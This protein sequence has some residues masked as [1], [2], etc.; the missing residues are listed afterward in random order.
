MIT[1][2]LAT[3]ILFAQEEPAPETSATPSLSETVHAFLPTLIP[4]RSG[5]YAQDVGGFSVRDLR[6]MAALDP[7]TFRVTEI[8]PHHLSVQGT[9]R[10]RANSQKHPFHVALD[11][12]LWQGTCDGWVGRMTAPIAFEL[13]FDRDESDRIRVVPAT[14]SPLL[15]DLPLADNLNT[16][17]SSSLTTPLV[18]AGLM[19]A[20]SHEAN[21]TQVLKTRLE[22]HM[23]ALEPGLA[24]Q[25]VP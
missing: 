3:G 22:A 5:P 12:S 25:L 23:H 14:S 1:L 7:A 4:R 13:T 20:S 21:F 16:C 10:L 15:S 11:L 9:V 24:R 2:W 19:W 17:L 18:H 8:A 6:I